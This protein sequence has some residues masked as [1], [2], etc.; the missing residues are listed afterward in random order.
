MKIMVFNVRVINTIRYKNVRQYDLNT[1][2]SNTQK[3]VILLSLKEFNDTNHLLII[4]DSF[5]LFHSGNL[6]TTLKVLPH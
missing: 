2:L 1:K 3:N 5:N 6:K 4:S